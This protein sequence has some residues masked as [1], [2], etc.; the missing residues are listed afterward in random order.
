VEHKNNVKRCFT[1]KEID[2][3]WKSELPLAYLLYTETFQDR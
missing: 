3:I 1:N 2:E